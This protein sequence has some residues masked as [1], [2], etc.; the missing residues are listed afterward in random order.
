MKRKTQGQGLVEYALILLLVAV[1]VIVCLA[2]LGPLLRNI[3]TKDQAAAA[4]Q[5]KTVWTEIEP[6][7]PYYGLC[8]TIRTSGYIVCIPAAEL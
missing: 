3:F 4:Q 7:H 2:V 8:Y 1:V 6:P 5:N